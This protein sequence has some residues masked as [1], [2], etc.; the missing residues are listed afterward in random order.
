M[1]WINNYLI[2][3]VLFFICVITISDLACA[4]DF[5]KPIDFP[6]L[7]TQKDNYQQLINMVKANLL[8]GK[9]HPNHY[10]NTPHEHYGPPDTDSLVSVQFGKIVGVYHIELIDNCPLI[11]KDGGSRARYGF[12]TK[13]SLGRIDEGD[14]GEHY[15]LYEGKINDVTLFLAKVYIDERFGAYEHMNA[16]I[17][18]IIK[19]GVCMERFIIEW[20]EGLLFEA[21]VYVDSKISYEKNDQGLFAIQEFTLP[22]KKTTIIKIW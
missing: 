5:W 10:K 19:D 2:L 16:H 20:E 14:L 9:M 13:D 11:I 1:V 12:I 18:F 22:E 17:I 15:N 7:A 8:P 3:K 21:K 6:D 4:Q